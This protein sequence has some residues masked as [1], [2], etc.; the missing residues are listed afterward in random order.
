MRIVLI[1]LIICICNFS[2][3]QETKYSHCNCIETQTEESYKVVSNGIE[4]ELGQF[5]SGKRV[6]FWQSKSSKGTVIRKANYTD[7]KL[8]G[9]YELFHFNGKQKL[10][11]EFKNGIPLGKWTYY[12]SKGKI[13]KEGMF[14]DGKP[15]GNWKIMDQKGKKTYAEYDFNSK[16]ELISPN[17]NQ[18]FQ[19]GGIIRDD[20]SGQWLVLYL[21]NRAINVKT[22][23]LGGYILA[24]DLF[25]DY[26]NIPTILMDA[27]THFEFN[28]TVK[29]DNEVASIIS[30]DLLKNIEK[31]DVTSHSLPFMV[32]TNPPSKLSRIEHSDATINF[33]KDQIAEYV[34]ISAPWISTDELEEIV[35]RSPIVINEVKKW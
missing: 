21:P 32:D 25:V 1:T 30:V 19:K 2:F 13:I 6:G 5:L 16:A 14:S 23:P 10:I 34:L 31:F 17:T 29:L 15:I 4:V 35:I 27:Y 24:S 33:L 28:T 18:Y 7:G 20:Q 26:F 11:A 3:S 22:K 9:K 8:N 12:N